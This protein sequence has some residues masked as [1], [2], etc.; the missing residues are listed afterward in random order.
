EGGPAAEVALQAG[1]LHAA[2]SNLDRVHSVEPGVNQTGQQ[3]ANA[4]AAMQHDLQMGR[5]L[6]DGLPHDPFARLEILAIHG[7]RHLRAG[8]HSQV[9]AKEDHINAISHR[10][11]E[12]VEIA[13]V[14]LHQLIEET[15]SA[16]RFAGQEH[17]EVIVAI[18]ELAEFEQVAAEQADN[19]AV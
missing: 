17:E 2:T 18:K 16:L 6:L 10:I 7:G 11:E 15:V 3:L 14:H 4:T 12:P 5:S 19:R 8:L 9:I 1:R 13:Q